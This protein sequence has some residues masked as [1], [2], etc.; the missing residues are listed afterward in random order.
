[1][2]ID[3]NETKFEVLFLLEALKTEVLENAEVE[4]A[5]NRME[6]DVNDPEMVGKGG[7]QL[8]KRK[9]FVHPGEVVIFVA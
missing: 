1:V 4:E 3:E 8:E 6:V 7:E 2:Q 5:K 9:R